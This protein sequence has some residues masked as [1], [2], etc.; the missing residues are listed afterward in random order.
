MNYRQTICFSILKKNTPE[1]YE[2]LKE[3]TDLVDATEIF[4]SFG[5]DSYCTTKT[6]NN[7]TKR[8]VEAYEKFTSEEYDGEIYTPTHNGGSLWELKFKNN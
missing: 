7:R 4:R 8:A 6:M 2:A 5:E 3:S 1:A